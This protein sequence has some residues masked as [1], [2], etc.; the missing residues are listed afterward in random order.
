MSTQT[1]IPKTFSAKHEGLVVIANRVMN[2]YARQGY[3][4]FTQVSA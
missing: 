2:N 4:L 1:F 3:D